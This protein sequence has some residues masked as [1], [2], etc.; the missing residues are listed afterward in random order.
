MANTTWVGRYGQQIAYDADATGLGTRRW[1]DAVGPDVYKTLLDFNDPADI[2]KFTAT[3]VGASTFAQIAGQGGHAIITTA[4][5]DGD[6]VNLQAG[7]GSYKLTAN[8]YLYFGARFQV[9]EATQ[10][11]LFLGL[12]IVQ[13]NILGAPASDLIGFRKADATDQVA[14]VLRKSA[15][16][17]TVAGVL[18]Q[19]ADQW[20]TVEVSVDGPAHRAYLFVDGEETTR[21][22]TFANIPDS[23]LLIPSLVFKTGAASAETCLVDWLRVI[24][25]GRT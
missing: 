9:S 10:S 22:T 4:G 1:V 17:A 19:D 11:A 14:A 16:E 6:G 8:S 7:L 25:I 21:F 3:A 20:H 12:S 5:A 15:S 13:T 24:G 23:A 2:A 18:T